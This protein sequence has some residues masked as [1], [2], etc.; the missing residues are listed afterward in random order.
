MTKAKENDRVR[1]HYKGTMENDQVFDDSR[2]REPIE[3]VIG[4]GLL[5][6]GF[7]SAIVGME[8]GDT[9]TI[10]IPAKEGYGPLR[11]ELVFNVQRSQFPQ[12]LELELGMALEL[13]LEEE[14]TLHVTVVDISEEN[15]SLDANHPLAG[16]NLT[17][18]LELIEIL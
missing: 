16:Q 17:F 1:V 8:K 5:L 4:D 7:E 11:E 15:V 12:D 18:E 13:P 2:S 3:F 9:K 6:Q 10:Q 14:R